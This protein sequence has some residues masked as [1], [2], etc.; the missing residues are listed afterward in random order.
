MTK[1]IEL[2]RANEIIRYAQSCFKNDQKQN[3]V[4]FFFD[5]YGAR[6]KQV[7]LEYGLKNRREASL[8]ITAYSGIVDCK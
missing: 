7:M 2:D 8:F 1:P 3:C 5:E 4:R 6:F